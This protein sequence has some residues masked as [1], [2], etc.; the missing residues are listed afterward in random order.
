MSIRGSKRNDVFDGGVIFSLLAGINQIILERAER[1][2]KIHQY[3][4]DD[5]SEWYERNGGD[6]MCPFRAGAYAETKV[7]RNM[8]ILEYDDLNIFIEEHTNTFLDIIYFEKE[9]IY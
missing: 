4:D 5:V 8:N 6:E 2:D 1:N 3:T 7:F 9:D